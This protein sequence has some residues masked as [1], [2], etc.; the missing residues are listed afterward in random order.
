MIRILHYIHALEIGGAMDLALDLIRYSDRDRFQFSLAYH[1]VNDECM[2]GEFEAFDVTLYREVGESYPA[3]VPILQESQADIVHVQPGANAVD[4]AALAAINHEIPVV[5]TIGT[6]GQVH[7]K[8]LSSFTTP[9]AGSEE[10]YKRRSPGS[11]FIYHGVDLDRL[12]CNDK[13]GAKVHWGLDPARLVIGWLGRFVCFKSPLAF[14]SIAKYVQEIDPNIQ[15]VMFGTHQPGIDLA[16]SLTDEIGAD[17][18][19]PGG[20][21]EKG[22]AYGCMD[23]ACFPTWG[24]AFGRVPAEMLG[25]GVPMICSQCSTNIE[26][27]G[28]HALYL[29]PPNYWKDEW[30]DERENK[31]ERHGRM[32]AWTILALLEN[33]PL[34]QSMGI[35][36]QARVRNLFDARVMAK[37][38][39]DLYQE[40]YDGRNKTAPRMR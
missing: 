13:A 36:G 4:P 16:T 8:L 18:V 34:R 14:V 29:A 6:L 32:W 26:I 40:L 3:L 28:P 5:A 15:F 2:R 9:V 19:F 37:K 21:R 7:H 22:L 1:A 31:T 11:R 33:E 30:E 39:N 10:Q 27:A 23:I 25:A 12:Q 17:V 24:E 35:N 38:Y 20:V